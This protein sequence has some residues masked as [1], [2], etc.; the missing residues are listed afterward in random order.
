MENNQD[1]E[2][3]EPLLSKTE[4]K[5]IP[6]EKQKEE[7]VEVKTC[8]DKFQMIYGAFILSV[9]IWGLYTELVNHLVDIDILPKFY[10]GYFCPDGFQKDFIDPDYHFCTGNCTATGCEL[11][12]EESTLRSYRIAFLKLGGFYAVWQGMGG[13][14]M[15][16]TFRKKY[17][18]H[19]CLFMWGFYLPV[20]LLHAT[21]YLINLDDMPFDLY[22]WLL[23]QFK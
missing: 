10:I 12:L 16:L 13:M 9:F 23:I 3:G 21:M 20:T 2:L 7:P 4:E 6:E 1:L 8:E 17:I 15:L 22:K 18:L 5:Q 11:V 19:I 14:L